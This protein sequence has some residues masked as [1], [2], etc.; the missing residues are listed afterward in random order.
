VA[1]LT[2]AMKR[3]RHRHVAPY[4][5]GAVLDI[6]CGPAQTLGLFSDR[7][8]SY[9]GIELTQKR[10]DWN[11]AKFPE[12]QFCQADL[13][14][15]VLELDRQF[16]VVLLVAV[17]EHIFNQRHLMEQVLRNLKPDGRIVITTPTPFG[18]DVVHRV[19][20]ALGLFGRRASR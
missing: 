10:V 8:E 12:H 15:D 9:C 4:V 16:D 2:E 7:I 1:L 18:N 14:K 3:E 19:G 5:R 11:R 17:I 13:E 20:A 6:A